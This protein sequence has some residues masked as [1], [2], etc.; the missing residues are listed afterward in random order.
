MSEHH[1]ANAITCQGHSER[2][3]A[4]YCAPDT[5]A[6][7]RD[8][9]TDSPKPPLHGATLGARLVEAYE[10]R[11]WTRADFQ[12]A[13]VAAEPELLEKLNYKTII[14]WEQGAT[15]RL[16]ILQVVARVLGYE[17]SALTTDP[18]ESGGA[19]VQK[20]LNDEEVRAL[21]AELGGSDKLQAS[22]LAELRACP[23]IG[24]V[25]QYEVERVHRIMGAPRPDSEPSLETMAAAKRAIAK[26]G[27]FATAE[28]V[29]E[30]Y[31]EKMAENRGVHPQKR[32][33]RRRGA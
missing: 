16:R 22:V 10:A 23:P 15:P 33:A 3:G 14:A 18:T 21:V 2:D 1:N 13:L 31:A 12:R 6:L 24:G 11:G 7:T 32:R 25:T 20:V 8:G 28:E 19:D 30:A 4:P 27:R 26:G 9:M 17:L 29:R 5:N